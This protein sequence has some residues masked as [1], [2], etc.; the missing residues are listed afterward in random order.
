MKAGFYLQ[1]VFL[2]FIFIFASGISLAQSS[3]EYDSGYLFEEAG[4][5]SAIPP[6]YQGLDEKS[7]YHAR[8]IHGMKQDMNAYSRNLRD[9]RKRFNQ[10]FYGRKTSD[11]GEDPFQVGAPPQLPPKKEVSPRIIYVPPAPRKPR[12]RYEAP[13]TDANFAHETQV[14]S[15]EQTNP[16]DLLAFSVQEPGSYHSHDGRTVTPDSNSKAIGLFS[17][18]RR[19]D[20]YI[21]PRISAVHPSKIEKNRNHPSTPH[22]KRY[23]LGFS[24]ALAAGIRLNRWRFGIAAIYQQNEVHPDSWAQKVGSPRVDWSGQTDSSAFLLEVSHRFPITNSFYGTLDL[25][26]GYSW[27]QSSYDFIKSGLLLEHTSPSSEDFIWSA[28]TGLYWSFSEQAS[29]L[30][31]Y[32]YF[33][34]E[35]VPT[36]NIDLGLEFGF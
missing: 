21:M 15:D 20:Y 35:T 14:T 17:K 28:G 27:T 23:E 26:A 13:Q 19:F 24:G 5:D 30:L 3:P 10:V 6:F 18:P 12:D 4:F 16:A 31:G 11:G 34:E 22:Y 9:L 7:Y 36:H 33:A 1:V 2:Y 25:G 29:L 8:Q 32:R